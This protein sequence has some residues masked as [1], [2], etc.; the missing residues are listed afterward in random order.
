MSMQ[1][2]NHPDLITGATTGIISYP[3]KEELIEQCGKL[4]LLDRLLTQLR[5][6]GHRVLIFS[7]VHE[8]SM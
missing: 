2:C 1:V 5:K 7:Q 8:R 4:T 6:G 3:P